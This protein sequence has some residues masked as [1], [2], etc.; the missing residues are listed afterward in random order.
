MRQWGDHHG[1]PAGPV[2]IVHAGWGAAAR[3]ITVCESCGEPLGPGEV[4]A[5]PGPGHEGH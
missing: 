3:T 4:T 1:A 5:V 2:R